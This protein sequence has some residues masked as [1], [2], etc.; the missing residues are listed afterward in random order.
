MDGGDD[1]APL[2]GELAAE[3]TYSF[4][5]IAVLFGVDEADQSITDLERDEIEREER[6]GFFGLRSFV[7]LFLF[8]GLLS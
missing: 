4:E 2:L 5:E 8:G 7:L 1:K 3:G 6:I